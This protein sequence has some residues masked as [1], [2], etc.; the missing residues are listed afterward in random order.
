[1]RAFLFA[2]FLLP[3]LTAAAQSTDHGWSPSMERAEELFSEFKYADAAWIYKHLL[4]ADSTDYGLLIRLSESWNLHGLDLQAGGRKDSAKSA[5]DQ[6]VT[7]AEQTLRHHADS[8][9]TYVN[10][11]AAY[12]DLALF[13]GGKGKVRIGRQV[14]R[15]CTDALLIDSTNVHALTILGVFHRELSRLSWFEKL[16]ARTIYG[17]LPKGSIEKSVD[18][19][20]KAIEMDSTALFP[21]Y[22][23][24]VTYRRMKKD[25]AAFHQLEKVLTLKPQNSEEARYRAK[26]AAW[27]AEAGLL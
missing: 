4:N 18:F 13:K 8:A 11:A 12:G 6:A 20:R 15:Y 21:N 25:D 24:A 10:L 23:L 22:S 27:L 1:M 26:A 14:E 9:R 7:Y 19:L 2:V 16:V 17:G 5:F 3:T